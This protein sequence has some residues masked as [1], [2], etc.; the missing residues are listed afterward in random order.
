MKT[1]GNLTKYFEKFYENLW[2]ISVKFTEDF[3]KIY[4]KF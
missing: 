1:L 2:E 4:E 3:R